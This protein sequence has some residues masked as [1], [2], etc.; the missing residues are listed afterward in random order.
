M[1]EDRQ[2]T[3]R[4]DGT[5]WM[6]KAL[7]GLFKVLPMP[8]MYLFMALVVPFY[9]IFNHKGYLAIYHYLHRR[10]GWGPLKAFW[11]C[12]VNHFLFGACLM[13]R[14]AAYAGR[15]FKMEVPDLHL[16]NALSEGE[17]GFLMLASHIGNPEL[18]GYMLRSERKRMNAI[19]FGGEKST[20]QVSRTRMLGG[21]NIR[22]IEAGE[23]MGWLFTLGTALSDGEIVSIHADRVFGSP[24]TLEVELLD[25]PA[26]IPAGPFTIAA[27]RDLPVLA[28]FSLKTGLKR[29][30][31]RLFRL[32]SPQMQTLSR[33]EKMQY[34]ANSYSACV[35][36][37][38]QRW[39]LQWFNFYEFW[40]RK[41]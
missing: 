5:G 10:M 17:E 28:A 18:C 40:E 12:C 21:N 11:G 38:L 14:F 19:S 35:E 8:L 32:D 41:L 1:S 37:V 16:F 29:Y 31:I 25:A 27:S 4:T 30:H 13:D 6:H 7:T 36:K 39:P 15:K 2:W 34:L 26:R 24:K 23:D 3:G 9:L 20:V 33:Q 22:L